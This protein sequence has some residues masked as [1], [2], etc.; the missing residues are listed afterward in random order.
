MDNPTL[1]GVWWMWLCYAPLQYLK[2]PDIVLHGPSVHF[3]IRLALSVVSTSLLHLL[4]ATTKFDWNAMLNFEPGTGIEGQV[5]ATTV[6]D[7][8]EWKNIFRKYNIIT[9]GKCLIVP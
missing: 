2:S 5:W 6:V 4:M 1:T 8:N 7:P 9:N 3:N